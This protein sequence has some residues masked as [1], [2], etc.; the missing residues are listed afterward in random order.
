MILK[1]CDGSQNILDG[2]ITWRFSLSWGTT[3]PEAN[4]P[5]NWMCF[6]WV[7]LLHMLLPHTRVLFSGHTCC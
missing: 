1:V 5:D 4:A 7:L 2:V 6:L 3:A